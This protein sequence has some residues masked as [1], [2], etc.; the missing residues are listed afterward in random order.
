M[1]G[2]LLRTTA[3]TLMAYL[4]GLLGA[5]LGRL[6]AGRLRGLVYAAMGVLLAVTVCDVLPDA[7]AGLSWP[8]FILSALSG[9]AAFWAVGKYI[10][11]VCPSCAFAEFDA[12]LAQRL[13]QTTALL[14][15]ALALHSVMD[16]VAVAVAGR[17]AGHASLSVGWGISLHKLP[18]GLAL[19]LLLMGAGYSRRTALGWTF[20]IEAATE[21]GGLLGL[22]VLRE[23]S[24]GALGLVFGH[25]G[26]GFVYLILSTLGVFR[27]RHTDEFPVRRW[28]NPLLISSVAFALT[29]LLL[30][31]FDQ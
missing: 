14:M 16:G 2:V 22:L 11:P 12:G 27:G 30:W 20:A 9:L 18:E 17:L 5:A 23:A 28:P 1:T 10:A 29:A 8:A 15:V 6:D 4:G 3:A 7:K 19:V 21:A 31:E 25:I 13:G 24:P 26:G